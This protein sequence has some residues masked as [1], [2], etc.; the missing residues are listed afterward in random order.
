MAGLAPATGAAGA[1]WAAGWAGGPAPGWAAEL[2]WAV[3]ATAATAA[4]TVCGQLL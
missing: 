4:A 2:G 1:C 3:P